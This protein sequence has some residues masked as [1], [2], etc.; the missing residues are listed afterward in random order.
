MNRCANHARRVTIMPS[1]LNLT[2]FVLIAF[3]A[4]S[5]G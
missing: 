1:D 4:Y 5:F 2:R 3:N